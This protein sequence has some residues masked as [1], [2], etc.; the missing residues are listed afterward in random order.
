MCGGPSQF[1]L[2]TRL[3]QVSNFQVQWADGSAPV[4]IDENKIDL[5]LLAELVHFLV[6][7]HHKFENML[8]D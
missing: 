1:E 3:K 8:S 5:S 7:F 4:E 6:L 2:R